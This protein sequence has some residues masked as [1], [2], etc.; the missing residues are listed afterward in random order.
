MIGPATVR[1]SFLLT[2]VL[3]V[4]AI[5][6]LV[7]AMLAKLVTDAMYLQQLAALHG[8]RVAVMDALSH[9][10]QGDAL[11]A[12]AYEQDG[13]TLSLRT[14]THDGPSQVTYTFAPDVVRRVSSGG[15]EAEWQSIRL[16]FSW[17]IESGPRADVLVLDFI[18]VPPP[19]RTALPPRTF[20]AAFLLPLG[21]NPPAHPGE[22]PP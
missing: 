8:N 22:G 3:A 20:S 14:L 16:E 1:R 11:A 2:E 7:L 12:V 18:E 4:L 9:R 17:R 19:R 13:T 5:G 6:V 21:A 15:D 10:L